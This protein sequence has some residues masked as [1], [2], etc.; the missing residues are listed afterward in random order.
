MATEKRKTL[1]FIKGGKE[2]RFPQPFFKYATPKAEAS[3]KAVILLQIKE[4]RREAERAHKINLDVIE[5]CARKRFD[6]ERK[7]KIL[8]T[9]AQESTL[10]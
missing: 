10:R 8:F 6:G 9:Y 7:C 4:D 1:A 2:A 5:M 3:R